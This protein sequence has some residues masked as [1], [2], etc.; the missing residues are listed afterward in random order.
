[1][2]TVALKDPNNGQFTM[3]QLTGFGSI[4]SDDREIYGTRVSLGNVETD[5]ISL[6]NR[7]GTLESTGV[8]TSD[9]ATKVSLG[10]LETRVSALETLGIQ[11][12]SDTVNFRNLTEINLSGEKVTNGDFSSVTNNV[13]TNFTLKNGTLDQA[14]LSLGIVD[15]VGGAVAIQQMFD[16]AIPIGSEIVV[17]ATREDVNT[18]NI[19]FRPVKADGNMHGNLIQVPPTPDHA[20]YTVATH[21]M[22][23]IRIDTLHGNRALSEISVFVGKVSGGT[24][25]A[26]PGGGLEKISG[27]SGYNTGGSSTQFIEGNSDG[28]FQF[29]LAQAPV[30]V[31]L[32]YQDVDFENIT[33]FRLV[34]NFNGSAFIGGT[35]ALG[36]GG[37]QVGD[38]FRIRHYAATNTI[39]FQKRQAIYV[40]DTDFCLLQTCGLMPNNGHANDH[41]FATTD[42]PLI[43]A[44]QTAN[45]LTAGEYYRIHIVNTLTGN[46]RIY[47]TDGVQIGWRQG[48]G[49]DWEVQKELGQDYVSFH[50][51]STLTNGNNLFLDVSLQNIGSRINDTIIVT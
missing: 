12:I 51:H 41:T 39:Q 20:T 16:S 8:D 6:T 36:P 33:P 48:R 18:G 3:I 35:Q 5:V 15:G 45:G 7:V 46:S 40:D 38:F 28:Y 43:K 19:G 22:A 2:K 30:R 4:S 32:T 47:T 25:Q 26:N 23:G 34:L 17:K 21:D 24:A 44:K 50:T 37:Y 10:N 31:G 14:Q 27:V 13:P 1:M 9:L 42:R 11:G 29:Q 49:T